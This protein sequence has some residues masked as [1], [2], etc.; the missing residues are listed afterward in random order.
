MKKHYLFSALAFSAFLASCNN[1][2]DTVAENVKQETEMAE[3]V[4]ATLVSKGMAIDVNG[5]E[6]RL[7]AAGWEE[8]DQIGM[9]WYNVNT[10][11]IHEDQEETTWEATMADDL[12]TDHKVYANHKFINFTTES[13]VYQGAHFVYFPYQRETKVQQKVVNANGLD[14]TVSGAEGVSDVEY[15]MFNRAFYLSAQ[16]FVSAGDVNLAGELNKQ[17]RLSAMVNGMT[18]VATPTLE[19]T[20]TAIKGLKISSV[21]I[22]SQ[23]GDVFAETFAIKPNLIPEVIMNPE[24]QKIDGAKTD[25]ALDEYIKNAEKDYVKAVQRIVSAEAN[26]DLSATR[27]INVF[28]FPTKV[29]YDKT[30]AQRPI[31]TVNVVSPNGWVGRFAAAQY[32]MHTNANKATVQKLHE[33]LG[34]QENTLQNI[35][36]INGGWTTLSLPIELDESNLAMVWEI[37]NKPQWDDAVALAE[38]I[39]SDVTFTLKD[40]VVFTE[41]VNLP[42]GIE[43]TVVSDGGKMMIDGEIEWPNTTDLHLASAN[44]EITHAATLTINGI[45]NS[46]KN[47]LVANEIVNNGN[48]VLNEYAEVGNSGKKIDNNGRIEVSYGSYVFAEVGGVVAFEV[49]NTTPI[50]Q[51]NNLI[52]ADVF[53]GYQG[54][55]LV[56]TLIVNDGNIL[57]LNATKAGESVYDPYTGTTVTIPDAEMPDLNSINIELNGGKVH[58]AIGDVEEVANVY[59]LSGIN[60]SIVDVTINGNLVVEEGATVAVDATPNIKGYKKAI[61]IYG[62]IINE[63]TL[64][65]NVSIFAINVENQ[66]KSSDLT[67]VDNETVW[68]TTEYKQGGKVQGSV[69]KRVGSLYNVIT[70][71]DNNFNGGKD[72]LG[73]FDGNGYALNAPE[74]PISNQGLVN[75]VGDVAIKNLT[76]NGNGKRTSTDKVTYGI[77]Q[78]NNEGDI[79]IDNVIVRGTAYALN[80]TGTGSPTHKMVVTN[81]T[82]EGWVSY[83]NQFS[84][85]EFTNCNFEIGTFFST[86][87]NNGNFKP[88]ATT[89][90]ENCK[91][92]SKFGLDLT[93][94]GSTNTVTLKNCYVN[95]VK[96]TASNY[97]ALFT[98]DGTAA[99]LK[100]L[101]FK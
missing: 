67:V 93:A 82:F 17:F 1:D 53:M 54:Q 64:K 3:V 100:Q 24:T 34:A 56:N 38:E 85:V 94:I 30:A 35:L 88:Y 52:N 99:D 46:N 50:Y 31:I 77:Y 11:G 23:Q 13:N 25:K 63:G 81:S 69:M 48:I 26:Y 62:D 36:R 78:L 57:N 22:E 97:K 9:G 68:Y 86:P 42:E 55:A 27:S 91:F 74:T 70:A 28:T 10:L 95:G 40:D 7:T 92:E 33:F 76:I 49:K 2:I 72:V 41:K 39:G 15:D 29:G 96:V 4:G 20:S 73:V 98:V 21:N 47:I 58:G 84:L 71:D 60:N 5:L 90:L 45:S 18:V 80:V 6:S 83:A 8:N 101:Y 16:D 44:I 79:Y 43:L 65:A 75:V 66:K 19:A 32:S 59:V 89:V 12:W 51:I 37:N 61:D 87:I 14:F